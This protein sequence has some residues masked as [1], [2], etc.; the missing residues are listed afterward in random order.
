MAYAMVIFGDGT[1]GTLINRLEDEEKD[2]ISYCNWV[3]EF[4]EELLRTKGINV[5]LYGVDK[6]G[7]PSPG[8]NY[9]N[10]K[11]IKKQISSSTPLSDREMIFVLHSPRLKPTVL[12]AMFQQILNS[13]R[14]LEQQ[15]YNFKLENRKLQTRISQFAGRDAEV[16]K[17]MQFLR[18]MAEANVKTVDEEADAEAEKNE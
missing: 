1:V 17:E 8:N 5:S 12:T 16:V 15:L 9:I 6:N 14:D 7:K 13:V 11:I 10:V 18:G 3:I 2:G 4:K